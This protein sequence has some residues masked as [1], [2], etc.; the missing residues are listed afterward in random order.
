M[1]AAQTEA[2]SREQLMALAEAAGVQTR[3]WLADGTQMDP[4]GATFTAI[5]AALDLP[6]DTRRDAAASL[7]RLQRRPW[8]PG[9]PPVLVRYEDQVP[10]DI[11]IVWDAARGD[12]QFHWRLTLED[13]RTRGASFLF[14][15]LP[16]A[17]SIEVGGKQLERRLFWNHDHL[18]CG[19]HRF[20]LSLG[21]AAEAAQPDSRIDM[22]LI[23]APRRCYQPPVMQNPAWKGWG[24]AIQLYGLWSE[25]GQGIGGFGE[26]GRL[27]RDAAAQGASVIGLNPLHAPLTQTPERHSPYSP[28]S[29]IALNPL[30]VDLLA[31]PES[32]DAAFQKKLAEPKI[33][34]QLN[35][36]NTGDLVDYPG[37]MALKLALFEPLYAAFR[38]RCPE[39]LNFAVPAAS[40][41]CVAFRN[42]VEAGGQPLRDVALFEALSEHFAQQKEAGP[43]PAQWPGKYANPRTEACMEF[44]AAHAERVGFHLYRF[45]LAEE[46]MAACGVVSSEAGLSVGLYVDV[47]L[48]VDPDGADHWRMAESHA[49]GMRIGAPPDAFNPRGQEWGLPP[50]HPERMKAQGYAP[51]VEMLRASMRFA[52]ALRLDHVM[53][54]NRLYWVP[55]GASPVEGAYVAYPQEDLLAIVA[56][57]SQRNG[58]LVIGEALGTV[59]AGFRERLAEAGVLSYELLPFAQTGEGKPL[60]PES[61]PTSA[62]VCA[63]THDLP[64][65][66]G[67]WN[68][69]DLYWRKT[70]SLFPSADVEQ[71]E[72]NERIRFRGEL[73]NALRNSGFDLGKL[74]ADPESPVYDVALIDAAHAWLSR[75]ASRLFLAQ[76]ED[77]LERLECANL[78]GTVDQHPNWRRRLSQPVET[79]CAEVE[80]R[81]RLEP[82]RAARPG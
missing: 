62:A 2:A 13:G 41:R 69:R 38:Q 77:L 59:P 64:T 8:R 65:L 3:Y 4:P 9:M 71:A 26:L 82:V 55:E 30:Y 57:E 72:R 29:R 11:P 74:S 22:A 80:K 66:C 45:W 7:K 35:A 33:Q 81:G 24:Y 17:E 78:P 46:Q 68:G 52:G 37:V 54:L 32:D 18:P 36:L 79:L 42:F 44:A 53:A 51:F 27:I 60:P 1:G 76:F 67:W 19:Y 23:I 70:L 61:Y 12:S 63:T 39:A 28:S 16:R 20:T 43:H 25:K 56:L 34:T 75:S 58:C 6:A 31:T 50:L 5:L 15:D 73:L 10:F 47:A 40:E 14:S 21:A 48:G 49:A